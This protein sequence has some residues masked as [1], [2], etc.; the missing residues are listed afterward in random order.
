MKTVLKRDRLGL[1]SKRS[2][3]PRVTHFG[4]HDSRAV[5][6]EQTIEV[7]K[8]KNMKG[9]IKRERLA[10]EKKQKIWERNIRLY[11]NTE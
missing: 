4:A 1:G 3:Q 7:K 11:M 9:V 8:K 10:K 6:R 2:K 5:K